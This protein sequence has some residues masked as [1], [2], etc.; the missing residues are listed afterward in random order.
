[1]RRARLL[2]AREPKCFAHDLGNGLGHRDAR[3][4]LRDRR[5]HLD[6]VD[7]LMR[8]EV[9]TLEPCLSGD[10]DER[11]AVELR[12]G[13]PGQQVR[14]AG[15]QGREAHAWERREP[16]VDVGHERGGLPVDD[17]RQ[18]LSH[19]LWIGGGP[20]A[21]KTTLSRLL[22]GKWDLKIY[23]LDWHAVRDHDLRGG[24]ASAAFAR[25]SMD[26]RWVAPSPVDL[27]ERSI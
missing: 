6:H 13:H 26:E 8:L 5:E 1:M 22:A 3:A 16:S 7:V 2:D 17:L 25:L 19:V 20:Q 15:A 11:R 18:R 23:N 10:G 24:A 4:P 12:V 14:R 9:N 27:L 21:G